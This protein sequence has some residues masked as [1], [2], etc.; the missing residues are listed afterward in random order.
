MRLA[1][2]KAY[3]TLT[4]SGK[5]DRATALSIFQH[6][7]GR[8]A[9]FKRVRRLEF[10]ELPKTISGKIRRVELRRDEEKRAA[11][12]PA[13]R[14]RIPGGGFPGAGEVGLAVETAA[15]RAR[16]LGRIGLGA[17]VLALIGWAAHRRAI[18]GPSDIGQLDAGGQRRPAS[19]PHCDATRDGGGALVHIGQSAS[20]TGRSA[21]PTAAAVRRRPGC[22]GHAVHRSRALSARARTSSPTT[23]STPLP[24]TTLVDALRQGNMLTLQLGAV[25]TTFSLDGSAAAINAAASC[26]R[27]RR[28]RCPAART[29]PPSPK[30]RRS[31][32]RCLR[33]PRHPPTADAARGRAEVSSLRAIAR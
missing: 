19:S 11:D 28:E 4:A 18:P 33:L 1:V 27:A 9:P 25:Y 3:V 5:P 31:R 6:L 2:P 32:R 16:M 22:H 20:G 8:L 23:F 14:R 12:E 13:R 15:E 10:A 24:D 7:R 26:H 29:R 30:P 21:L 17:A